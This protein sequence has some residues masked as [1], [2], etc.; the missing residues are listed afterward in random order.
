M[1]EYKIVYDDGY[2]GKVKDMLIPNFENQINQLTKEGWIAKFSKIATLPK[3]ED[4]Q[5]SGVCT[6]A[7]LERDTTS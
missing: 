3:S 4:L 2:I 6:Y 7:L 5:R 1:K